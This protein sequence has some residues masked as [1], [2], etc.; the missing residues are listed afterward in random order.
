MPEESAV[1]GFSDEGSIPSASILPVSGEHLPFPR[2]NCLQRD[3]LMAITKAPRRMFD[4]VLS[5][6]VLGESVL[7]ITTLGDSLQMCENY[8][9]LSQSVSKH[10]VSSHFLI[11][12]I[13][14]THTRPNFQ[15]SLYPYPGLD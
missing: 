7:I 9:T 11:C 8:F 3:V 4:A 12:H 10:F 1:D 6:G 14:E 15:D 2:R 5:V 13:R